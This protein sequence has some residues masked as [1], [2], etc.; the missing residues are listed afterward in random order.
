MKAAWLRDDGRFKRKRSEFRDRISADGRFTPD[1]D[2]YH[3]IVQYACPWAHRTLVHRALL[4]LD[5]ITVDV[6][7]WKMQDD[8]SWIFE[9]D[10]P[11]CTPDSTGGASSLQDVYRAAAPDFPGI[12]TVPVLWDKQERTIV[13]NESREIIRMMNTTLAPAR[14]NE[15]AQTLLPPGLDAAVDA[16]ID[17]NYETVNNAVYKCGFARTQEAYD[18][19]IDVLF[20][21]LAQLEAHLDGRTWLVGDDV[22]TRFGQ[23]SDAPGI[24]SEADVCLWTTL[25]R[26]DVVYHT[27]FKCNVAKI[28][29]MPKLQA[30]IERLYRLPGVAATVEWDHI[31]QHYYWSHTSINPFR[32]VPRGPAL[33]QP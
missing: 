16:M 1:A 18:E 15:P 25:L 4:G 29:E 20:D 10:L 7:S 17:A 22:D 12:G 2:R 21:R 13:N 24:L 14:G 33:L 9:P 6:V 8:G 19:S 27:H 11:G 28:A 30:F 26:F 3:L 5:D 31:K 23:Q 32:I